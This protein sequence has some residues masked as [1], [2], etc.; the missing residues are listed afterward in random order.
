MSPLIFHHIF[1]GR[2][3]V[4]IPTVA[5]TTT[6]LFL[7]VEPV[8]ALP[9]SDPEAIRTVLITLLAQ[10]NPE[11]PLPSRDGYKPVVYPYAGVKSWPAFEK[12]FD[13]IAIKHDG[14]EYQIVFTSRDEHGR[15]VDDPSRTERVSNETVI[16][17]VLD[18]VL[19]SKR[20]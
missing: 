20:A 9:Y 10:G 7:D 16:T 17:R 18:H 1:V 8:A 19:S 6:G 5:R 13:C 14:T 15:V 3:L 4:I 11:V 2:N 12:K